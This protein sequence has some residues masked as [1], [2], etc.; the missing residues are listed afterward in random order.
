MR[1]GQNTAVTNVTSPL[2]EFRSLTNWAELES[3]SQC[4][5]FETF[6]RPAGIVDNSSARMINRNKRESIST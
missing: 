1:A 4:G 6:D 5:H 3:M 2:D